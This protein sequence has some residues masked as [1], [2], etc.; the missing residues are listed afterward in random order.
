MSKKQYL[1]KVSQSRFWK[2]GLLHNAANPD[3][4]CFFCD[5]KNKMFIL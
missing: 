2:T 4:G 1:K 5:G 3:F